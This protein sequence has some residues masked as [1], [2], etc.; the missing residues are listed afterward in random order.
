MLLYTVENFKVY[1]VKK[2]TIKKKYLMLLAKINICCYSILV[3]A[4]S[5]AKTNKTMPATQDWFCARELTTVVN[6][7]YSFD[8]EG[9]VVLK[10][11]IFFKM[12][13]NS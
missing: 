10:G 13:E 12:F 3:S 9:P 2:M 5:S 1:L 6:I 7:Q 8:L 4:N 11:K